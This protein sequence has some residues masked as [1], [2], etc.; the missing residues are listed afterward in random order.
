MDN[1]KIRKKIKKTKLISITAAAL[2]AV[3]VCLIGY[4]MGADRNW[5]LQN[6]HFYNGYLYSHGKLITDSIATVQSYLDPLLNSFYYI[7]ISNLSPLQVNLIIVA[8]QSLTISSVFFLSMIVFEKNSYFSKFIL[9]LIVSTSAIFGP[10]FWSEIGG[11]MGDTLLVFPVIIS[12]IFI[13]KTITTADNI[14]QRIIFA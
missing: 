4:Y 10:I 3:L 11:T 7:L 9:S 1:Q 2:F 12:I 6:Y 5:D 13:V 14:K 8:L